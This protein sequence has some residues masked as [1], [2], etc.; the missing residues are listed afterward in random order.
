MIKFSPGIK[1]NFNIEQSQVICILSVLK[2][3]VNH[4]LEHGL[5]AEFLPVSLFLTFL[6]ALQFQKIREVLAVW[7]GIHLFLFKHALSTEWV[8]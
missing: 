8:T 6:N 4:S 5:N 2:G 1:C 3:P 7:C